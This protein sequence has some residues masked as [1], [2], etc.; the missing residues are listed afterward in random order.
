MKGTFRK[1][2]GPSIGKSAEA[3]SLVTSLI[4]LNPLKRLGSKSV[5][6]EGCTEIC[7]HP[8]FSKIDWNAL[9]AQKARRAPCHHLRTMPA[10]LAARCRSA[11]AL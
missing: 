10:S 9:K 6:K 4:A 2:D 3:Q 7:S 8:F 5:F 11:T 1:L